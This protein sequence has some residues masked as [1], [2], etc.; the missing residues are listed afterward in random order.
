M[1][2]RRVYISGS[3]DRRTRDS[4]GPGVNSH[5]PAAAK[6]ATLRSDLERVNEKDDVMAE[7][8]TKVRATAKPAG[9]T[10]FES[11]VEAPRFDMP[12]FEIPNF[13]LPKFEVP[14]LEIP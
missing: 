3:R 12:K 7:A 2:Q 8:T 5:A 1:H 9:T 6:G 11:K 4:A 13:G 14:K 10:T